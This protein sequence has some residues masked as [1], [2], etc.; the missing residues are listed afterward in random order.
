MKKK[1]MQ[2]RKN[3]RMTI[4]VIISFNEQCEYGQVF[5]A[6][7][8]RKKK[9]KKSGNQFR[10]FV[11]CYFFFYKCFIHCKTIGEHN[12]PILIR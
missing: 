11:G 10:P 3:A 4:Q 5:N 1:K 6:E 8:N 12:K 7:R 9:S 2:K